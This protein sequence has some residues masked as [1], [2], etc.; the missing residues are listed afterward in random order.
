MAEEFYKSYEYKD[1]IVW[2]GIWLY[3]ATGN[4]IY[5]DD[6][7]GR[8][9]NWGQFS[10]AKA[11]SFSWDSKTLGT[12]LL[13]TQVTRDDLRIQFMQPLVGYCRAEF[14]N[15]GTL[16]SLFRII[17]PGELTLKPTKARFTPD[18]L[19]WYSEWSPNRYA[20]NGAF[21]CY[22]ISRYT[23][24]DLPLDFA[25]QQ[26]EYVLG[27]SGRSYVIGYSGGFEGP[28]VSWPKTPHHRGSSCPTD[29]SVPCGEDYVKMSK[30]PNPNV[31]ILFVSHQNFSP[32]VKLK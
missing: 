3:R 23:Y 25:I 14:E 1:E 9:Y 18:G 31:N 2:A 10:R 16:Q 11:D 21:V 13:L 6:T 22:L 15:K 7:R 5:Y 17:S 30:N 26:A 20:A 29:F 28:K 27:S 8:Y 24:D 12:Q 4:R 19:W 32:R